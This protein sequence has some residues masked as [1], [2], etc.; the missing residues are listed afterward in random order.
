[1]WK[2]VIWSCS[3]SVCPKCLFSLSSNALPHLYIVYSVIMK[4]QSRSR[5]S[6]YKCKFN[7]RSIDFF[8]VA[9]WSLKDS[10]LQLIQLTE[11]D[12]APEVYTF[13]V[14]HY[15]RLNPTF[16]VDSIICYRILFD[17]FFCCYKPSHLR[18]LVVHS[19][20]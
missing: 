18:S 2:R 13:Q 19:P 1:M 4:F 14:P 8:F 12:M 3:P 7:A 10:V 9:M 6:Y 5:S 11:V 20:I 15:T 16:Q 17:A